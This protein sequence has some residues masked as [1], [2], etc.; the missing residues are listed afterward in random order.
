MTPRKR[1]PP[2]LRERGSLEV[3]GLWFENVAVVV[4]R[5]ASRAHGAAVGA[6][7]LDEASARVLARHIGQPALLSVGTSVAM[8]VSIAADAGRPG[9]FVFQALSTPD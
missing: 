3:A 8:E 4:D 2:P 1:P 6:I 9:R 7:I 5:A